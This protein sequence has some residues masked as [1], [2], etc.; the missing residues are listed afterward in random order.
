LISILKTNA[1][2]YE[3]KIL[4]IG[5]G[6][7]GGYYGARLI[8]AGADVTF[9]VRPQRAEN[10]ASHGL[11]V[12]SELG[13]F[14][15]PVRTVLS[16][17]LQPVYDLIVLSCKAYDLGGAIHDLSAA[18][19]QKTRI[20]PFLN[21]LAVYDKL[22]ECFG[23]DRVLGGVA[24]IATML[25]SKGTIHHLGKTDFV[26][27][28]ARSESTRSVAHDFHELMVQSPGTRIMSPN[29]SQMLWNKWV[30]LASGAAMNCL[31]RGNL[32]EV[33]ATL[34]GR[35]FMSQAIS[36]CISVAA[37]EGHPLN[38]DDV[39]RL[40]AQL[41]DPSSTWAA[42]LMRDL[43]QGAARLESEEIV[44]DMVIRAKRHGI[45]IP[46]MRAA[47]CNLQV[48]QGQRFTESLVEGLTRKKMNF[49][50]VEGILR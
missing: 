12:R 30:G 27:V 48:Y 13:N 16:P 4:F 20:L 15:A 9:L 18:V 28:G 5:A 44:G 35:H 42:S 29:M 23:R 22:D 40:H 6:A 3:L 10:L 14:D 11:V 19:G 32:S 33:L 43:V 46:L 49:S 2:E 24:Y 7:I 25:D 17:S 36:E 39:Q 1:Q 38:D 37:A 47:Y 21:G 31:M 50:S 45:D 41:L 8:Q 26:Q 34:D